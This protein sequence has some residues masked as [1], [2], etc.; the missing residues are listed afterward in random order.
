MTANYIKTQK[1]INM[2]AYGDNEL[3]A[4]IAKNDWFFWLC[5][6]VQIVHHFNVKTG[7]KCR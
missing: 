4:Y 5:S 1:M 7:V 6:N 2:N 3:A